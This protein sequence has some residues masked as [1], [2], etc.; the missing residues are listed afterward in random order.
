[1]IKPA[2]RTTLYEDITKQIIDQIKNGHWIPG[3]KIPGEVE[4]S[5]HFQVSRNCI[6]ESLKALEL[7]GIINAKAGRGTYL[8]DGALKNIHKMEL[9]WLLKDKDALVELMEIRL[10]LEVQL[11]HM[12]AEKATPSQI[13]ELENLVDEAK[14]AIEE[15]KYSIDYGYDFH[16]KLIEISDNRIMSRFLNSITDEL[17]AQRSMLI[18]KH[19]DE[20]QLIKEND[21]HRAILKYIKEGNGKEASRVMY[22]HLYDAMKLLNKDFSSRVGYF[23]V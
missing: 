16:M 2:S 14:K 21:E 15:K 20:N 10:L 8:S 5:K 22:Q 11:A 6:R 9:L 12:A 4:L 1:M 19:L 17:M 23:Q 7:S 13:E 3:E 18:I